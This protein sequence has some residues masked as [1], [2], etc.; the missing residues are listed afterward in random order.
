MNPDKNF[1]LS[2][3]GILLAC[4]LFALLFVLP[5]IWADQ[6]APKCVEA[7]VVRKCN[8]VKKCKYLMGL[9]GFCPTIEEIQCRN[10]CVCTKYEKQ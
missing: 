4:F 1:F 9:P 2:V 10:V 3:C 5:F 6:H 8:R 7:K